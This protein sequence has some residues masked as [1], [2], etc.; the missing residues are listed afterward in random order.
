M[1]DD[2]AFVAAVVNAPDDATVRLVYA[3]WLEERGDPRA[4]LLRLAV[5]GRSPA[6]LQ[7]LAKQLDPWWVGVVLNAGLRAGDEV[8][9]IGGVLEGT[10]A[11]VQEV[12]LRRGVARVCPHLFCRPTEWPEVGLG[13][14]LRGGRKPAGPAAA[15]GWPGG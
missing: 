9:V 1:T 7:A 8:E 3:D 10:R 4:E 14:V 11:T 5:S 12:D 2:D 6:R 13:E 15:P